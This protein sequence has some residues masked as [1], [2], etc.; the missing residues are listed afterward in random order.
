MNRA[1][2]IDW[3][4]RR[5]HLLT[6]SVFLLWLSFAAVTNFPFTPADLDSDPPMPDDGGP[7]QIL[8]TSYT[9]VSGWPLFYLYR[10]VTPPSKQV[11][12]E[13][14]FLKLLGSVA[15][16]LLTQVSIVIV[17][18]RFGQFSIALL[19]AAVALAGLILLGGRLVDANDRGGFGM[20]YYVQ[21]VYFLPVLGALIVG[22]VDGGARLR[23]RR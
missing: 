6:W 3:H 20:L 17:M 9:M 5:W 15:L 19:L 22:L 11:V 16:I 8:T 12:V 7:G 18:Q 1:A 21:A 14:D 2:S 10:H 23:K 13:F 4:P